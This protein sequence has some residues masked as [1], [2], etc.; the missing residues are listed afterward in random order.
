MSIFRIKDS[1]KSL[2]KTY[3]SLNKRTKAFIKEN[4]QQNIDF[5][6]LAKTY[7]YSYSRFRHIFK[8]ENNI[9][10]I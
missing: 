6:L 4:Y 9:S 2:K 7:G 1:T 8:N 5:E 10:L 3:D